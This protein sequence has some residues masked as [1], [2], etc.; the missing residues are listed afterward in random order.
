VPL[1]CSWDAIL[2]LLGA[3]AYVLAQGW[4]TER[5]PAVDETLTRQGHWLGTRAACEGNVA[6]DDVADSMTHH[7]S[8]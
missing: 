2:I 6:G 1:C 8:A 5:A 7:E 3:L 4:D